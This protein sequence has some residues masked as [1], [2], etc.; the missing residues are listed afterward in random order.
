MTE[1]EVAKSPRSWLPLFLFLLPAWLIMSAGVG[2]WLH[3][4]GE[5]AKANRI[6]HA[7]SKIVSA[8]SLADDVAKITKIIGE[9]H[10]ATQEAGASLT[11]MARMIEG[12]LGPSNTGLNVRKVSGPSQWPILLATIPGKEPKKPPV[13]L[14]TSYDSRPGSVGTEANAT[15]VAA[16]LSATQ[17]I[18]NLP[19]GRTVE[20][21]FVPH[22]NDPNSPA[23]ET[24]TRFREEAQDA[25]LLLVIEAMGAGE[26]LWLTSRDPQSRILKLFN[27]LGEVKE[28]EVTCLNEDTDFSSMLFEMG[29]PV[30]RIATRAQV[31]VEDPDNSVPDPQ[32]LAAATGRLVTL[33]KR[34]AGL[35]VK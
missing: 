18:V 22:A 17:A 26:P 24:A 7:F 35:T 10:G 3:L 8:E 15:G 33:I 16:L 28:A 29:A 30:V 5:E 23:M 19:L 20:I 27:D 21:A 12:A 34:C 4:R 14:V 25:H 9:R 6:D 13:W 32:T 2:I 11:S 1:P 31:F